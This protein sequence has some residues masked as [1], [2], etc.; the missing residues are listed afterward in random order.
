[1]PGKN[2]YKPND[3]SFNAP[4]FSIRVSGAEI[5]LGVR[6]L[7]QVV[8]YESADGYAD[9]LKLTV[10][11]PD[12]LPPKKLPSVGTLGA[13]NASGMSTRLVDNKIFQPGNEITVAFG[14]G[15]QLKHVGR[16]VIRKQRPNFPSDQ[17]PTIE[18]IAYTKDVVMMDNAPQPPEESV[19]PGSSQRI[20]Q[21]NRKKGQRNFVQKKFSDV[22]KER[23]EEYGFIWDGDVTKEKP[24]DF[25]QKV[26]MTDYDMVNGLANI[27]GYVFWVD[28]DADGKWTL[29]FKDPEKMDASDVQDKKYTFKYND[30][31]FSS[32]LTFEPEIAT[33]GSVTELWATTL[34]P[35]TGEEIKVRI[36]EEN[37]DAPEVLAE[38]S[39]DTLRLVDQ[40]LN[41][42]HTT[43][44]DIKLYM[45]DFSFEQKA[46]RRIDNEADLEAWARQWFRRQRENFIIARGTTIGTEHLM[47]RQTHRIQG[48][49]PTLTGDYY[50]SR[51]RHIMSAETG[52]MCEF[53]ARKVVPRMP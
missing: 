9:A 16:A 4:N 49:G 37:D 43:G 26:G 14:W 31:D 10:L 30:G 47:A 53:T 46:N 7:V 38:V 23:A 6:Q 25:T 48:V 11:D 13:L 35:Q 18:V 20:S 45:N 28:G 44:S 22:V 40:A 8:E 32:L 3:V 42:P 52:Y 12:F 41:A 15:S 24:A 51:V 39:G 21:S 29:H 34:N 50:F 5:P 1:M 17:I 27:T 2:S 33:Q 19:S 36:K